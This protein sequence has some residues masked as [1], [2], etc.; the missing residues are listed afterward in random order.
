MNSLTGA[1]KCIE[2]SV[3]NLL[4]GKTDLP[5]DNYP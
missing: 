2:K 3:R 1:N 4:S 5:D